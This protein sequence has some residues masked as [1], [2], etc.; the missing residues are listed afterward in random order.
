MWKIVGFVKTKIFKKSTL[1]IFVVLVVLIFTYK[2]SLDQQKGT[3]QTLPDFKL[4]RYLT[5][6]NVTPASGEKNSAYWIQFKFSGPVDI[7]KLGVSVYPDTIKLAKDISSNDP[8]ILLIH[9]DTGYAW[10]S[11][12]EYKITL[13][14]TVKGQE[15]LKKSIDYTDNYLLVIEPSARGEAKPKGEF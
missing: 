5:L 11:G 6:V 4:S 7:S 15:I 1:I 9:P 2:I 14:N 3:R 12:V 10:E 13:N 8:S